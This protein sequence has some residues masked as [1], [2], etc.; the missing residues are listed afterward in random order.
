VEWV[1]VD[2]HDTTARDT[3]GFGSTGR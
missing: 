3:Y 2:A 1:E